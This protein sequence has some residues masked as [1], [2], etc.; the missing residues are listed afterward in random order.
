MTMKEEPFEILSAFVDGEQAEPGALA[1]ALSAPGAR[2]ALLDFV[3]LRV[4]TAVDRSVPAPETYRA[5]DRA[6]RSDDRARWWRRVIPVPAPLLAAG[7]AVTLALALWAGI[8]PDRSAPREWDVPPVPDRVVRF[9]SGVDWHERESG[10]ADEA[11]G[12]VP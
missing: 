10:P 4:E 2:E 3:L 9:E 5:I 7:A 12:A 8:G 11:R 6:L 1:R